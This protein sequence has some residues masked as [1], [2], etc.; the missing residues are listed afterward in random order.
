MQSRRA[1]LAHP[2]RELLGECPIPF[3]MPF[4]AQRLVSRWVYFRVQ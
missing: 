4:T 1:G 3:E 2:E